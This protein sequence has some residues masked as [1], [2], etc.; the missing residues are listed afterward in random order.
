MRTLA[1]LT[2]AGLA[3]AGIELFE[4]DRDLWPDGVEYSLEKPSTEV[5]LVLAFRSGLG[6]IGERSSAALASARFV[7][8]YNDADRQTCYWN[9]YRPF[10]F[11]AEANPEWSGN[12]EAPGLF[13]TEDA[14]SDLIERTIVIRFPRENRWRVRVTPLEGDE[15]HARRGATLVQVVEVRGTEPRTFEELD[16]LLP[17]EEEVVVPAEAEEAEPLPEEFLEEPFDDGYDGYEEAVAYTSVVKVGRNAVRA[18][19][20]G[21][22]PRGYGPALAGRTQG[23]RTQ[24]GR[25]AW[26]RGSGNT[27]G[28]N[29]RAAFRLNVMPWWQPAPALQPA[30][31]TPYP[32]PTTGGAPV[33]GTIPPW[34]APLPFWGV[35]RP[36]AA[37][38]APAPRS[39]TARRGR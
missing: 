20:S 36:K 1:F 19:G 33:A 15:G 16:P 27:S 6:T 3:H 29:A 12:V 8:E 2:L 32:R 31:V 23:G 25:T 28:N 37:S 38:P 14:S 21:K 10:P 4:A 39:A 13:V 35:P 24:A 5:H 7:V 17:W 11:D 26:K 30:T 18:I 22:V 9:Q 34:G